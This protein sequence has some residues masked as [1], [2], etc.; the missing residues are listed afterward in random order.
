MFGVTLNK[1]IHTTHPFLDFF[2]SLVIF[3]A[4]RLY[5]SCNYKVKTLILELSSFFV[6]YVSQVTNFDNIKIS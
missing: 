6:V 2:K 4:G 3:S 1:A 5:F